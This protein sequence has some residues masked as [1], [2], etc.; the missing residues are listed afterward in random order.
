MFVL[1]WSSFVLRHCEDVSVST[2]LTSTLVAIAPVSPL[3]HGTR[4][5]DWFVWTWPHVARFN[6]SKHL[7]TS[8]ATVCRQ[9]IDCVVS[10]SLT[11]STRLVTRIPLRPL[12]D[13][14][15]PWTTLASWVCRVLVALLHFLQRPF[16]MIASLVTECFDC[17]ETMSNA[18]TGAR[19]V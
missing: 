10:N 16:T 9:R 2:L 8:S 7:V 12:L 5:W 1:A 17:S 14:I 19:T 4:D 13:A 11:T 6:F 3:A 18:F 15:Q